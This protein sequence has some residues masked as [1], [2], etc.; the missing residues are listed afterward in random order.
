M[1]NSKQDRY[2]L[3]VEGN[4]FFKRNLPKGNLPELRHNKALIYKNIINSGI[5]FEKVL[6]YGC[7][8]G[9]LL[10]QIKKNNHKIQC[11]G[12]EASKDAVEFGNLKFG[13][14]IKLIHGTV[15]NNK[16]NDNK[17]FQNYFDLIIIDDVFGWISRETIL[18][19]VANIDDLL[20]DGGHIFIRDF[21]PDKRLK[22]KNYHVKRGF[23]FNYKVPC[24][25]AGIFLNSGI[26]EVEWETVFFDN[27]GISTKYKSDNKF[28]Y[29]WTD[30]IL[31]KSYNN[32]F[33]ESKKL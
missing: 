25:H 7:N 10:Y 18:Q 31:K 27:I 5:K 12:V 30:I 33:L 9:D 2:Y 23:I 3:D 8:Y 15:A 28:I 6:E 21:Y 22:T 19:S 24:S 17:K 13:K 32:Y 26:Y 20:T 29:R 4:D 1:K 14:N 16:I 11:F